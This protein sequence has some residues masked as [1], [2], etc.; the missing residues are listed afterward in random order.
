M[1][2][3]VHMETPNPATP[4]QAATPGSDQPVVTPPTVTPAASTTAPGINP[5]GTVTISTEEFAKLQRDAA[6]ARSPKG[7][8]TY[9]RPSSTAVNIDPSD[10][11]AAAIAEANQAKD[12]AER[13]AMQLEVHGKVRD[14]LS[15]DRFKGIPQSTKDLILSKPHV[16]TDAETLEDAMFDIEDELIKLAGT[17]VAPIPGAPVTQPVI[18]G[19]ETPAVPVAGA[20]AVVDTKV[21][22]P[23]ENLRGP[24]RSQAMIRNVL[25]TPKR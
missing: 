19:R 20:P 17:P 22:E 1:V 13:R 25:R 5:V 4:A 2:Y 10:P 11:A 12:A 24:A 3:Y 14:L 9:Q 6:R 8:R 18:P 16:L 23:T 7:T 21:Q 15:D